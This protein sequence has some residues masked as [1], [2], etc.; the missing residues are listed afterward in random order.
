M[1]LRIVDHLETNNLLTNVQY[2][3][4]TGRGTDLATTKFVNDILNNFDDNK[5]TLSVFLDLSKA[6]DCVDH[7]ILAAKL[8]YF[9]ISNIAHKWFLDYLKNRSHYVKYNEHTSNTK[10]VNIGVPQ[11]SVLGPILFLIYINDIINAGHAGELSLFA[12][13]A[14]YYE[15]SRDYYDLINSVNV[16]LVHIT[17]WFRANRLSVNIIKSE[18]MLFTRKMSASLFRLCC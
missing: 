14:N 7:H 6:F 15:S 8:K 3:Y 10:T 16:N 18:A 1:S 13:D 17:N 4:R 9:G 2:A 5:Y 11:G 12:D